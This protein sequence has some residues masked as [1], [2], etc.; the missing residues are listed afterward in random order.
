M[1]YLLCILWTLCRVTVNDDG[2][3]VTYQFPF[4]IVAVLVP[5]RSANISKLNLRKEN[6]LIAVTAFEFGRK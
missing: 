4:L 6:V 3:V 1:A 5:F 2:L